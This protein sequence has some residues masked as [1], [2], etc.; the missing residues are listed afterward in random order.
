M[1]A[2]AAAVALSVDPFQIHQKYEVKNL[3]GIFLEKWQIALN[4]LS[5]TLIHQLG[6]LICNTF[7]KKMGRAYTASTSDS[8]NKILFKTKLQTFVVGM[9]KL[10]NFSKKNYQ[11]FMDIR[12]SFLRFTSKALQLRCRMTRVVMKEKIVISSKSV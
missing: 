6:V 10:K 9:T 2:A 4:I 8:L 7:R 5:S 11:F 3:K 12:L 1:F